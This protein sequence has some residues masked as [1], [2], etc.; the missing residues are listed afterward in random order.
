MSPVNCLRLTVARLK[1]SLD[2]VSPVRSSVGGGRVSCAAST[3]SDRLERMCRAATCL[4][5]SA[6][7]AEADLSV[8]GHSYVALS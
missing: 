6:V 2:E 3:A 4:R 1:A 7:G 8:V 5:S